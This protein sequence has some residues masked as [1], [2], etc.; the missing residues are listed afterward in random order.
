MDETEWAECLKENPQLNDLSIVEYEPRSANAGTVPS[1]DTYFTNET[2]CEQFERLF[3]ML[4]YKR[5]LKNHI[6]D[7]LVDNARTHTAKKYDLNLMSK[8]SGTNCPYETIEWEENGETFKIDCFFDKD[9]KKSKGLFILAQELNMIKLETLEKD[10][11]LQELR[12]LLSKHPAFVDSTHLQILAKRHNINLIYIPKFHC[13]LN[14]I[15][16]FWCFSKQYIRK[17]TDQKF[18][19]MIRLIEESKKEFSNQAHNGKLWRR[20]WRCI[21][22]YFNNFDYKYVMNNLYSKKTKENIISHRKITNFE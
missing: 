21:D 12:D 7:L 10:I 22:M 9:K 2:I 4:K 13:E 19:T 5:I 8:K 1:K 15:E 17:R 20:F 11:K 18:D 6:I 3:V 16:G 14:P